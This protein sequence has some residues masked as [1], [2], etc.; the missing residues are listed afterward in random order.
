MQLTSLKTKLLFFANVKELKG[1]F[2]TLRK[3]IVTE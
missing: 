2:E 1:Y 3:I